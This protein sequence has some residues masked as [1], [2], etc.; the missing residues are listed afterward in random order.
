MVVSLRN[1][2]H[3]IQNL[4]GGQGFNI[5]SIYAFCPSSEV[6]N[7]VGR[8]IT[9]EAIGPDLIGVFPSLCGEECY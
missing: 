1:F 9:T 2:K 7:T 8:C 6:E 5:Y 3:I 4:I